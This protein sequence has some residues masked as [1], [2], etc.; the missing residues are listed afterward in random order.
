MSEKLILDCT[1]GCRS[2]W[3]DK[4]EPH[5]LYCDR[6]REHHESDYGAH[7]TID[8]DPDVIADFTALPF[9]DN[10][11]NLIVFDPPHIIG[12][13]DGWIN[14]LYSDYKT[15]QDALESVRKGINECMRV[16]KPG[17]TLIFK[18]CDISVSTKEILNAID[19]KPLFGHRSGK[20][21]NTHWMC[22]MK[23]EQN[24]KGDAE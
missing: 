17:G 7:R 4:S 16:L 1:C 20:K 24:E 12:H 5:T 15:K 21:S 19:F 3:F 8:V 6:R 2:I 9:N 10:T 22:F 14:K 13:S 11:Y 18:W 23:F